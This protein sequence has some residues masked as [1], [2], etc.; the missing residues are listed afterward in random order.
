MGECPNCGAELHEQLTVDD[1]SVLVCLD[2]GYVD[3]R[4]LPFIP[5]PIEDVHLP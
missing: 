1:A 4:F 3:E 2:C 5:R